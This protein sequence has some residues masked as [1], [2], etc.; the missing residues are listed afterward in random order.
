M[1]KMALFSFL[2]FVTGCS[3]GTKML[4]N[5]SFVN[6]TSQPLYLGEIQ[7]IPIQPTNKEPI[8]P[9][10]SRTEKKG[11][12]VKI[13]SKSCVILWH[14]NKTNGSKPVFIKSQLNF[15]PPN[16]NPLNVKFTLSSEKVW[17]VSFDK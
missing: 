3:P 13:T 2:L 9:N 6:E 11:L 8:P 5:V 17:S 7:G 4:E 15:N 16:T 14:Q 12:N 1:K 10:S